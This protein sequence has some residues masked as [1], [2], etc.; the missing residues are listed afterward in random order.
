M[1]QTAPLF[2]INLQTTVQGPMYPAALS[3]SSQKVI[4]GISK[5]MFHL[6]LHHTEPF[7]CIK[8]YLHDL[9]HDAPAHTKASY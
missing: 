7:C 3:K 6:I 8:Q 5:L 2:I 9:A 1:H 4:I